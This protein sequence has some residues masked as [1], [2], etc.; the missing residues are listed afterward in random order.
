MTREYKSK[1]GGSIFY[2]GPIVKD[3]DNTYNPEVLDDYVNRGLY[4]EAINYIDSYSYSN[5][6]DY[7]QMQRLKEECKE[8]IAYKQRRYQLAGESNKQALDFI[9]KYNS[10]YDNLIDIAKNKYANKYLKEVNNLF[11]GEEE[12][13]LE[14]SKTKRRF[15]FDEL[16]PDNKQNNIH[17]YKQRLAEKLG[18]ESISDNYLASN[19]IN[20]VYGDE[21]G[22]AK[23]RVRKD[24]PYLKEILESVAIDRFQ[25]NVYAIDDK[26]N[27]KRNTTFSEETYQSKGTVASIMPNIPIYFK[28]SPGRLSEIHSII[29]KAEAIENNIS[30]NDDFVPESKNYTITVPDAD[31]K[32]NEYY[33]KQLVEALKLSLP[34]NQDIRVFTG[35]KSVLNFDENG[36]AERLDYDKQKEL[37]T[38]ATRDN[39]KFNVALNITNDGRVGVTFEVDGAEGSKN[40]KERER[41]LFTIYDWNVE[42]IQELIDNSPEYQAIIQTNKI[43]RYNSTYES[44]TGDNYTYLGGGYGSNALYKDSNG[45]TVRFKTVK[46]AVMRDNLIKQ[47]VNNI[48]VRTNTFKGKPIASTKDLS[49]ELDAAAISIA[50]QIVKTNP[51]N[52]KNE[53]LSIKDIQA[54]INLDNKQVEYARNNSV[55]GPSYDILNYIRDIKITLY[56]QLMQY[57]EQFDR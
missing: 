43:S 16:A 46:N 57:Y 17:S 2:N 49:T 7:I 29:K 32:V 13:E 40:R 51:V 41:L 11:D 37:L 28:G 9:D 48:L 35:P 50:A 56:N 21:D 18:Y 54:F 30:I 14:F 6:S 34:D 3:K 53:P 10:D 27:R 15:I 24:S 1:R 38:L 22:A 4:Q 45:N 36:V 39:A 20:I 42:E 31:P 12:I 8:G 26:G 19:G 23:V 44:L 52:T 55:S 47:Q 33:E 5:P 25:P